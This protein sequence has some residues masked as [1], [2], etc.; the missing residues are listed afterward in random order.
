MLQVVYSPRWFFG[1][2]AVIDV[3]SA[4]VLISLMLATTRY[5]RIS[6]RRKHMLLATAF[7]VIALGF[8]LNLFRNFIFYFSDSAAAPW[9]IS[10]SQLELS[11]LF[12]TWMIVLARVFTVTGLFMIYSLYYKN[13]SSTNVL[14]V[15]LLIASM[16]LSAY[17]YFIFHL[18]S[19]L[20]LA[21][22]SAHFLQAYSR[23][24]GRR[25]QL[26]AIGFSF[27]A[28]SQLIFIFAGLNPW[29]YVAGEITQLVGYASLL[30]MF[31]MV[32]Y[33]GKKI[34]A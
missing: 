31:L 11:T 32:R 27:I 33:Y 2:D 7:G 3:L 20:L 9:I 30:I 6:G 24:G 14:V 16:V 4:L 19:L 5:Y 26:L 22:I 15:L 13:A 29:F 1:V 12:V 17:A 18:F 8:V 21:F 25:R 28:L 34:A 10:F 23:S